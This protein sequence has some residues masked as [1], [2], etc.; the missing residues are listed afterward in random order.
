MVAVPKPSF[1]EEKSLIAQGVT[2]IAGLDEVGCGCLAGP[3]YAAA[4]ILPV[5]SRIGLIRDSKT[6]SA[7]QRNRVVARIYEEATAWAVGSATAAEVD[8]LNIRKAGALAMLRAAE[9]LSVKPEYL[10]VDAFK[11]PGIDI[12]Q[13]NIVRGDLKAK[14][15]AAA[16][17]VAKVA[18]DAHLAQLHQQYPKYGFA[19]H[20]G[21]ATREH[22]AALAKHGPC[23]EHRR[24]YAPVKAATASHEARARKEAAAAA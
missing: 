15:I 19:N 10:L 11:I 2:L 1:T 7:D 3:V 16:S 17:V 23:P 14:S 18:R 20:K 21:Y 24:S 4:V 22:R 12:P 6:L 8:A 5:N 13:K 9:A